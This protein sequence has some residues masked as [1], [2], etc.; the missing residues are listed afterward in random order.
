[1]QAEPKCGR[2]ATLLSAVAFAIASVAV[3]AATQVVSVQSAGTAHSREAPAG[4]KRDTADDPY[5]A[6]IARATAILPCKPDHVVVTEVEPATS[7]LRGDGGRVEAFV[8]RGQRTVFLVKGGSTLQQAVTGPGIYDLALA[9]I[10]W[11]EMAH[12][13]GASEPDARRA[14]EDLWS[15]FVVSGRIDADR[16]LRYLALLKKRR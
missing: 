11:H 10:I 5:R 15:Q 9:A 2:T 16:G 12:I 8:K 3:D 4:Q 7:R 14:Q 13:D 6:A 1:M